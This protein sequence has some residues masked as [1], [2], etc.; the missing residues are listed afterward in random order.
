MTAP[1]RDGVTGTRCGWNDRERERGREIFFYML[2]V[3]SVFDS[4]FTQVIQYSVLQ[5]V[6]VGRSIDVGCGDVVPI[7]V[8]GDL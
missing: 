6:G 8:V 7:V 1:Y 4:P 2:F 5:W 3:D